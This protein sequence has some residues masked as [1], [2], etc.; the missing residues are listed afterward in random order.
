MDLF[1]ILWILEAGDT[2]L[3]IITKVQVSHHD[4]AFPG[5]VLLTE[6]TN[7]FGHRTLIIQ[8][9]EERQ[10]T[11]TNKINGNQKRS[12]ERRRNAEASLYGF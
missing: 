5:H 4:D 6:I 11:K 12:I 2:I 7:K 8:P 9:D 1:P 3:F 10:S